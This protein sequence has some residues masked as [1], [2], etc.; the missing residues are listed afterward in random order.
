MEDKAKKQNPFPVHAQWKE[1]NQYKNRSPL[2][3]AWETWGNV[4]PIFFF[5][6]SQ[7]RGVSC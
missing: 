1:G 6:I 7:E 3:G 5:T 4:Y 2:L